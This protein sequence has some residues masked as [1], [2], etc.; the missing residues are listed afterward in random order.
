MT[1]VRHFGLSD[2]NVGTTAAEW[3]GRRRRPKSELRASRRPLATADARTSPSGRIESIAQNSERHQ[4]PVK[5][6]DSNINHSP[7]SSHCVCFSPL[8]DADA[9]AVVDRRMSCGNKTGTIEMKKN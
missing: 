9:D 1:T 4:P 7:R 8:A 5:D 6:I 3:I 2:Q